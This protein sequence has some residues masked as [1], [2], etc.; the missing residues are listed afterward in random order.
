MRAK[1]FVS[2]MLC[3]L[4]LTEPLSLWACAAA[5]S[6]EPLVFHDAFAYG[7]FGEAVEFY[8]TEAWEAEY[9]NTNTTDDFGYR[10]STPPTVKNGKLHFVKGDGVR[11]NWQELD[12]FS[13]FDA[14]R[15]YTITF[16]A[17]VTELGSDSYLDNVASW[18]REVYFATAGYY[19]QIEIRSH[20]VNNNTSLCGVR[21]GNT[22][23]GTDAIQTDTV[24][25]CSVVWTPNSGT[26]TTTISVG[27]A[28]VA[29][30]SRTSDDYKTLN[31]YT[32][33]WVWRCEN[34][35]MTVDNIT[36]T[37][38]ESTYVQ[39]FDV[40]PGAM[41][42]SG[43]WALEDVRVT[44]ALP[45]RLE[46]GKLK[47]STQSGVKFNWM[48]LPGV[49]AYSPTNTYTFEFD[50][51]ITDKGSGHSWGGSIYST[52]SLYVGFGG[53]YTLL[54][55]PDKDNRIDVCYGSSQI[56][57]VD[58]K[59]LAADLHAV[60]VWSGDTITG[61]ITD[62]DGN[63]LVSGSRQNAAF[64]DMTVEQAAMTNL[65]LR[66]EDGAVEIDN[67]TFKEE[68]PLLLDS[69]TLPTQ[70]A[71]Y[72]A[73]MAYSGAG[74]LSVRLGDKALFEI[75]PTL[76][77]LCTKGVD[78]SFG[79]GTYLF[80]ATVTPVQQMV[81][82]TLTAPDGA[83][84]RRG[85]YQLLEE[86]DIS[87]ITVSATDAANRLIHSEVAA[88]SVVSNQYV[89]PDSEPVYT[90]VEASIYNVVT[91]FDDACTTRNFAWT[92]SAA[93]VGSADM[94]L[95]YRVKGTSDWTTVDAVKE[96]EAYPVADEDYF[97]C[98]VSGLTAD[99]A[100]EYR[101]GVKGSPDEVSHWSKTY[102][103]TTAA[104][105]IS[106]FSFIAIGDTQGSAWS[107]IKYSRSAYDE[108]F[109]ALE[110]P[111]FIL[112]T[113]DVVE[114]G[115]TKSLWNGYFKALG[116]YGTDTPLFVTI[117]NHD[118]WITPTSSSP[119]N[120]GNL[121]FD[122]HFNHPNN[123]GTAALDM[124]KLA[125]VTDPNLYHLAQNSDE[126]I[127]SFNYGDVH[128]ISLNSGSYD[129]ANDSALLMAQYDWLKADL[130]NNKDAKWI[131][132]F[133]HQP[134]YHRLGGV[135]DRG[136]GIYS[137]LLEAYGV[138]LVIQGHSHLVTRTY[139]MKDGEIATK[140]VSDTIPQGTGTIYTTI[141]SCA[142]NHDGVTDTDHVEAMFLAAI[143]T[144][145]QAAYTIVDVNDD[146][147]VVTTRQLNG[148][149]LDSFTI[150]SAGNT[151]DHLPGDA[152]LD[153][154][155]SIYDALLVL[156][157]LAGWEVDV[158][159]LHADVNEDGL[160]TI[161]DALQILEIC[162]R[163]D[164]ARAARALQAMLRNLSI[165][166]L[167]IVAQPLSQSVLTGQQAR[168]TVTAAGDDLGYQWYIDRND[169]SG[170]RPLAN[171]TS[172]AYTTS[173]AALDH[174]GFLY[175]CVI[176]DAYSNE[177]TT[178]TAVLHVAYD[179][180]HTGDASQPLRCALAMLL[181]G[182][183]LLYV[184]RKKRARRQSN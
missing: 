57:W 76:L 53:W 9:G 45:P 119:A 86:N 37:D 111:A 21:A 34:G 66:C 20:P 32:R 50:L 170:W 120:D 101:I 177:L 10:T 148:L 125:N 147:L 102:T 36:V 149:V 13:D 166:E 130:E 65:V 74:S 97:K 128:F 91:S 146:A 95:Q 168:F 59:H 77:T 127:Y 52:R 62:R 55:M 31:K 160:V 165:T 89:L 63:V 81:S 78:G 26:I 104:E 157:S 18:N 54:S 99:T 5:A 58:E 138:D 112:H 41:I 44:N 51:Q 61:Q 132:I 134:V 151:P 162:F 29:T 126:T 108:A 25:S 153:G 30:G 159:A 46:D 143:P 14:S 47:L 181:S 173:P 136:N 15:T 98:D 152:D 40:T 124:S 69:M 154:Q 70:G 42:E 118:T 48:Q 7:S 19:N 85:F 71:V 167:Q 79:A 80:E 27:D 184:C 176:T 100:Y 106:A 94:A 56:A 137:D 121:Y 123:G 175:R 92:A 172:A 140:L 84:V 169:G 33:S 22:W 142:L 82:V 68:K 75:T 178:D 28:L 174:D 171:A 6:S 179:L 163:G 115:G 3:L 83:I 49:S 133:Q 60:F 144:S 155:V 1:K 16:D 158:S 180:P 87:A 11:L 103:F 43:L 141:G 161:D 4:M 23:V 107:N 67:F 8:N 73:E 64:T 35:Q 105:S 145:Q 110:D 164:M 116:D 38:G 129:H 122:Y 88:L 182:V 2:I 117:G 90:G 183:A 139:P 72:T 156:Q 135:S 131:V 93:F 39:D 17:T 109:E 150:T 114:S 113:G 12:G 96:N 24:Y